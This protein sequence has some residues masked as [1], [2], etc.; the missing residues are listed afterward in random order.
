MRALLVVVVALAACKADPKPAAPTRTI[1]LS[2][3]GEVI[4]Q[5]GIGGAPVNL[6]TNCGRTAVKEVVARAPDR[7]VRGDCVRRD[8][9]TFTITGDAATLRHADGTTAVASPVTAI[10]LRSPH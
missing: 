8:G 1:P 4:E 10:E 9:E 3:D 5:L 2:Y 7:V 6:W